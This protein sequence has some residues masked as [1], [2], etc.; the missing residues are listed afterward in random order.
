MLVAEYLQVVI[1]TKPKNKALY[2]TNLKIQL[3][4]FKFRRQRVIVK[5]ITMNAT[6]SLFNQINSLSFWLLTSSNYRA[7]VLLDAENDI[8]SI[9]V[10]HGG[11]NLYSKSIEGFSKRNALFLENELDTMVAGLLHLKENVTQQHL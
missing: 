2:P 9:S 5:T 4:V 6:F 7:S 8:Y 11:K 1:T 10:N 3:I